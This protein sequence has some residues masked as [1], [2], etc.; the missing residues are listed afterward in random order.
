MNTFN[1]MFFQTFF[2]DETLI[3]ILRALPL[4]RDLKDLILKRVVDD[5]LREDFSHILLEYYSD[6]YETDYEEY[7]SKEHK[8]F[9]LQD[10]PSL[11]NQ[12]SR[13]G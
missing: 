9:C 13:Q 1:K 3:T 2:D 7:N 8:V 5:I 10:G 6:D 12:G 4:P 11:G